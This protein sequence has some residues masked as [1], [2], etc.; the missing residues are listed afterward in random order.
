MNNEVMFC[1]NTPDENK[2]MRQFF[3]TLPAYV[4]E[5]VC[6]CGVEFRTVEELRKCA[7]NMTEQQ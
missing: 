7:H 4:R 2:E 6:Q 1:G 5:T 3:N